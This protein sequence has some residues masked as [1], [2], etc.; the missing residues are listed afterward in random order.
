MAPAS[1]SPFALGQGVDRLVAESHEVRR[2]GV[3][4]LGPETELGHLAFGQVVLGVDQPFVE[5]RA[6]HFAADHGQPRPHL[7]LVDR[8]ARTVASDAAQ[9]RQQVLAA[10][11]DGGLGN[12]VLVVA[13]GAGGLDKVPG[14]ERTVPMGNSP[15]RVVQRGRQSLALVTHR[16]AHRLIGMGCQQVARM[17][18]MRVLRT[19][20]QRII[21]AQV[22]NNAAVDH[23]QRLIVDL[24]ELR[25]RMGDLCRF[26]GILGLRQPTGRSTRAG[27]SFHAGV[28]SIQ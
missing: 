26:R 5:P 3:G 7:F 4:R 2:Q 15:V 27:S 21:H 12:F 6:R 14:Q 1:W 18:L 23:P 20:H 22:A 25:R 24:H 19:V 9:I 13:L 28:N 8:F 16:A 10:G 11:Q 17:D